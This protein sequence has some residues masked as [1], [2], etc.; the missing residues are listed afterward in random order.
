[1]L[2]SSGKAPSRLAREDGISQSLVTPMDQLIQQR[3]VESMRRA[4]QT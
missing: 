2:R 4:V 1:M 3:L